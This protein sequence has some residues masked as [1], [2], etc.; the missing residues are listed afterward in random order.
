MTKRQE[1]TGKKL[2]YCS[3]FILPM[4]N[5]NYKRLPNN[6]IN[7]YLKDKDVIVLIFDKHNKDISDFSYFIDALKTNEY[8]ITFM[9]DDYEYSFFLKIDKG[10]LQTLNLFL[11]GKY[12][13]FSEE[14][15][16]YLCKLYGKKTIQDSYKVMEYNILY[17]QDFKR[18]QIAERLGIEDWKMITEVFDKPDLDRE[19]YKSIEELIQLQKKAKLHN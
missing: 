7:A 8:Y 9:E 19:T 1:I 10:N 3:I 17:P 15:K 6:F 12:S 13:K 2:T 18:K 11:E 14:Y 4:C 5:L 16:K